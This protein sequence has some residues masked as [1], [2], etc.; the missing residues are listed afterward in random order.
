MCALSL[1]LVSPTFSFVLQPREKLNIERVNALYESH[2]QTLEYH[3]D[4]PTAISKSWDPT[5]TEPW[6]FGY[7]DVTRWV[8][9]P[10]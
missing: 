3:E 9:F 6:A 1:T 7:D 10:L 4:S 5:E 8:F 2:N